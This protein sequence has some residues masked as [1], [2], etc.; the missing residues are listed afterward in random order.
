MGMGFLKPKY[1]ILGADIAGTVEAVGATVELLKPGDEVYGDVSA[2]GIGGFAEFVSVSQ[3]TLA[4]K[5]SGLTFEE[6]AAVPLAAVT[7]LQGVRDWGNVEK[8]QQVL[9][10]GASGG[11]GTFAVQLA[12]ALGAEVTGVCSTGKVEIVRSLGADHVIDYKKEDF[13]RSG[14][15]YDLIYAANGDRSIW[16]YKRALKPKGVFV[17]SG[18]SMKQLYYFLLFGSIITKFGNRRMLNYV[19]KPN[20]E[21]LE[22]LSGLIDEGKLKPVMDRSYKLSEVPDAI[23]YVEDGHPRGKVTITMDHGNS[24][25]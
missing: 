18:G 1:R 15:Q 6:A 14:K 7:A 8:G 12:K 25:Q 10:H 3:H 16:D 11:V 5:P 22:F 24:Q 4:P 19:A 23:R 9:I 2:S 17:L 20:R 13:S 21:D